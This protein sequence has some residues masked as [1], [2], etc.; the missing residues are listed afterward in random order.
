M[1]ICNE[2]GH[3]DPQ[4]GDRRQNP[5]RPNR[6]GEQGDK[7]SVFLQNV[8]THLA[9]SQCHN[10]ESNS[11]NAVL[12]CSLFSVQDGKF[13]D[14]VRLMTGVQWLKLDK[15]NLTQ[16]PEELGKLLKLVGTL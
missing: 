1:A 14:A 15:T 10:P 7:E 2:G 8:D 11:M 6:N 5:V 3:S 16:I 9:D 12:Y 4:E 13:P